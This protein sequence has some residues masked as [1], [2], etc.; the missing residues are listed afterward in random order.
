MGFLEQAIL[1]RGFS[2]LTNVR[3]WPKAAIYV[4]CIYRHLPQTRLDKVGAYLSPDRYSA[5]VE[6]EYRIL[7]QQKADTVLAIV[8]Q[9]DR[10]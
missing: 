4:A 1:R 8:F 9:K 6:T 5:E 2:Y 3:S 10:F 7:F